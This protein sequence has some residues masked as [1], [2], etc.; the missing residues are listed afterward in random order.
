MAMEIARDSEEF[1]YEQ[2]IVK[3]EKHGHW[4]ILKA[5][6]HT[7]TNVLGD[8]QRAIRKANEIGRYVTVE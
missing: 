8:K 7:I 2:V 1:E 4:Q 3:Q 6:Y 5:N